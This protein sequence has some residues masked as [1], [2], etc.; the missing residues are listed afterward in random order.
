MKRDYSSLLY[1]RQGIYE[2]ADFE[3]TEAACRLMC[4]KVLFS[5]VFSKGFRGYALKSHGHSQESAQLD[6]KA[7]GLPRI[8]RQSREHHWPP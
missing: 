4:G 6:R 2:K 8:R 5:E 3:T 7:G 1:I